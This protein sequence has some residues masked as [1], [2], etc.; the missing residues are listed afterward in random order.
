M[1]KI[2]TIVFKLFTCYLLPSA[3]GAQ[4][5]P[6]QLS[7][8]SKV[9]TTSFDTV[10]LAGFTYAKKEGI[11]TNED[12]AFPL[13]VYF[14]YPGKTYLDSASLVIVPP[15]KT[16]AYTTYGRNLFRRT[17]VS[18]GYKRS[19]VM[20]GKATEQRGKKVMQYADYTN[21]DFTGATIDGWDLTGC[22]FLGCNFTN[23][24]IVNCILK[25]CDFVDATGITDEYLRDSA[26]I[27][28][29]DG[30]GYDF[31]GIAGDTVTK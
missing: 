10:K 12:I 24:K 13:Y 19:Q 28:L 1:K 22:N 9:M 29:P 5:N 3:A 4:D 14:S 30:S 25:N 7:A 27:F 6:Y 15:G 17:T 11:I 23:A 2:L 31:H 21:R 8:T 16:F 18:D 26:A 20:Q